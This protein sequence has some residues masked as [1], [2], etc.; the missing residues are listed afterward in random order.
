MGQAEAAVISA[1]EKQPEDVTGGERRGRGRTRGGPRRGPRFW[2]ETGVDCLEITIDGRTGY[3]LR[4][5]LGEDPVFLSVGG[6]IQIYSSPEDLENYLMRPTR[7]TRWP[8]WRCGRTSAR[9][10][11]TATPPCWPGRRT[12]TSSTVWTE[13]AGGAG[14]GRSQAA[15]LAVELLVDAA[16]Q[17]GDD[18][19]TE[20]LGTASPL[21]NLVSAT[22]KPDP[23]RLAPAPPFDDEAAAWSV[24]VDRFVGT[25]DW[26][27]ERG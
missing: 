22:I 8:A 14:G 26:D 20:A 19:T 17:R 10:S 15:E 1:A 18:E 5:Y 12:P 2:D 27:G 9:P 23:E 24:L 3:T 7:S 13:P 4:C 11:P 25:L 16:L 21:G 6:R